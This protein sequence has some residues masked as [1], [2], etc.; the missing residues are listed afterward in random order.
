[1][2]EKQLEQIGQAL[3]DIHELLQ[4]AAL[5]VWGMDIQADNVEITIRNVLDLCQE[6]FHVSKKLE[7]EIRNRFIQ[8]DSLKVANL[9]SLY[10]GGMLLYTRSKE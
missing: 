1:M 3:T 10:E 5:S 6:R 7:A 8:C 2:D 4:T 9:L